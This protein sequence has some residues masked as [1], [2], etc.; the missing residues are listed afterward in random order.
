MTNPAPLPQQTPNVII[1]SPQ[2]RRVA[3]RILDVVGAVLL[4]TM[5]VDASTEAFDLLAVTVPVLAG[6]SAARSV[7]GLT[8]DDQNTPKR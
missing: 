6:W 4:I 1:K 8:V 7:F 5:A 3:R 2:A